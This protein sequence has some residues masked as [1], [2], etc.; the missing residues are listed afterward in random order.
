MRCA[1]S[2]ELVIRL[3][4]GS[5]LF[6]IGRYVGLREIGWSCKIDESTGISLMGYAPLRPD[7]AVIHLGRLEETSGTWMVG[8]LFYYT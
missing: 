6:S 4:D 5:S 7:G 1:G 2:P 3:I 8:R